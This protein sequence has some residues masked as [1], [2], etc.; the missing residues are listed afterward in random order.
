MHVRTDSQARPPHPHF[1][2]SWLIDMKLLAVWWWRGEKER[3][4]GGTQD[5]GRQ[6]ALPERQGET[7]GCLE[8][9]QALS[10]VQC[11]VG[12]LPGPMPIP[13]S[14]G[15]TCLHEERLGPGLVS[16]ELRATGSWWWLRGR[17]PVV[18][19]R[20]WALARQ[21]CPQVGMLWVGLP[22]TEVRWSDGGGEEDGSEEAGRDGG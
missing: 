4:L 20:R 9:L 15:L 13:W 7:M 11:I 10:E 16:L 8:P 14:L 21:A 22:G 1:S 18:W 3:D 6:P 5:P 17:Q 19:E 12:L 2:F